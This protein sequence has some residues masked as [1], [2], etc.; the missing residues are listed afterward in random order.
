[1]PCFAD[2]Q[3]LPLK[4][5]LRALKTRCCRFINTS[6]PRD[7]KKQQQQQTT[8]N[9]QQQQQTTTTKNNNK[10]EERNSNCQQSRDITNILVVQ[11]PQILYAEVFD[12]TCPRNSK[13][14]S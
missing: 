8:N 7:I 14:I 6:K 4:F 2:C 5:V 10:K 11:S 13:P 1:M 3:S 9:K 12:I